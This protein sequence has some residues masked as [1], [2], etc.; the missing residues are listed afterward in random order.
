MTSTVEAKAAAT[1][2]PSLVLD[3][4]SHLGGD[5]VENTKKLNAVF[6]WKELYETKLEEVNKKENKAAER[7][8]SRHQIEAARKQSRKQETKGVHCLYKL[9][10]KK[11]ADVLVSTLLEKLA[12]IAYEYVEDEVKLVLNVKKEVEEFAGNLKAIQ[13]VL[14]DAEQRQ[15]KEA[16]VQ[17]WL[18]NL[19]EMSYQMVDVLDE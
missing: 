12:T 13:V 2:P 15:M 18:D 3:M 17:Q 16:N 1:A 10:K 5:A 7:L 6:K 8:K 14:E 9:A 19:K 11:M 4:M